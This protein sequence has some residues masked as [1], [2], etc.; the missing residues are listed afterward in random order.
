MALLLLL[1]VSTGMKPDGDIVPADRAQRSVASSGSIDFRLPERKAHQVSALIGSANLMKLPFD[2][3]FV[4]GGD[5]IGHIGVQM[6]PCRV[7][8]ESAIFSR[9]LEEGGR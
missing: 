8:S 1:R 5:S 4:D 9:R 3:A 7:N 6:F 2:C